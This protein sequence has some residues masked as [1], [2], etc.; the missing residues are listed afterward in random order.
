MSLVIQFGK[1]TTFRVCLFL[2]SILLA[3]FALVPSDAFPEMLALQVLL[4]L[5][6]GP[7]IPILWSMMADVADYSEWTT[8]RRSTGLAFAS[9]IFGLKLGLGVGAWLNGE[10]LERFQYS[11]TVPISTSFTLAIRLMVSVFPAAVL[12]IAVGVLLGYRL[13][14]VMLKRIEDELRA[15]RVESGLAATVV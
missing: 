15:R 5:I 2:S 10:L 11:A 6:F 8:Y 13:D 1:K 12:M 7:T 9:I 14:D 4:Q 3:A